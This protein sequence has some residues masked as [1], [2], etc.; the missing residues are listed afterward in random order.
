M[1]KPAFKLGEHFPRQSNRP[2][3]HL[4]KKTDIQSVKKQADL[5]EI[6]P[7]ALRQKSNLGKGKKADTQRHEAPGV[8]V[9]KT[10]KQPQMKDKAH[11]KNRLFPFCGHSLHEPEQE[12][13]DPH[14]S[15]EHRQIF[16][17]FETVKQQGSKQQSPGQ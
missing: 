11:K 3:H 2:L 15:Q 13:I 10:Q 4:R 8:S 17:P 7:E 9:F 1:R 16:G 5:F 12:I 6:S 14:A